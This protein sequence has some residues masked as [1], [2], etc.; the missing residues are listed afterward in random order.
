VLSTEKRD[1]EV[2]EDR[3]ASHL[4]L[5][6]SVGSVE[7]CFSRAQRRDAVGNERTGRRYCLLPPRKLHVV[8][9]EPASFKAK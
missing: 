8:T 1:E 6:R 3:L 7:A 2:S 4:T 5:L 9:R